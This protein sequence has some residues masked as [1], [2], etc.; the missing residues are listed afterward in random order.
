MNQTFTCFLV[1]GDLVARLTGTEVAGPL[2]VCTVVVAAAIVYTAIYVTRSLIC[3]TI[4][5]STYKHPIK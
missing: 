2:Q 3:K 1:A 4:V 5:H